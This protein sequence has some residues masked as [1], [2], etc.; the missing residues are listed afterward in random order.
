MDQ[1][2]PKE[3]AKNADQY[4]L[5]DVREEEELKIAKIS[6][7]LHIPLNQLKEKANELDKDK[8]YIV[9]CRSG[10]RSAMATQYL[11]S[12]GF[13]AMNLKGGI[14]EYKRIV[15]PTLISY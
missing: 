10:G 3:F 1:I 4:I 5:L 13:Q 7:C 2:T 6:P 8:I 11:T 14:L 12:L 9:I 15:D